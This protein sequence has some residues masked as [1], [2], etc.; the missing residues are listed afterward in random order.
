MH[1][2]VCV[3]GTVA[4]D[5]KLTKSAG[6]AAFCSFRL[7]CNERRYD[8]EKQDWVDSD[9]NWYTINS[10]RGLA[11]HAV[12]SFAKGDRVMVTGR[13]RVRDWTNGEKTGTSTVVEAEA[14]GHDL[15]WGTS[16]FTK[17]TV[18]QSPE[19]S[20]PQPTS[21][22]GDGADAEQVDTEQSVA[23]DAAAPSGSAFGADGFT[24]EQAYSA[25]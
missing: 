11:D 20:D 17:L 6:R 24:P 25:A 7:A 10:F 16:V 22:T 19:E 4:T 1:T 9:T 12:A 18:A 23:F 15:R 14:L 13:L 21:E 2:Q 5:P 3:V 8:T